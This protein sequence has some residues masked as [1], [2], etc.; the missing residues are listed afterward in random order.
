MLTDDLVLA[1]N[2]GY[3]CP[4]DAGPA[5]RRA[6]AEGIDMSLIER[7][8]AKSPWERLQD[9][10]EALCF[11]QMLQNAAALRRE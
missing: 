9:H 8:L 4:P 7:T 5:W 11:T 3:S 2:A 6:V 10:D 1:L